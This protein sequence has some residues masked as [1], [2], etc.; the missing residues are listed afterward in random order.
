MQYSTREKLLDYI[1]R[2]LGECETH[3]Y[4]SFTQPMFTEQLLSGRPM[5]GPGDTEGSRVRACPNAGYISRE[6]W[7]N[8]SEIKSPLTRVLF[9]VGAGALP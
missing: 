2:G 8:K 4:S 3:L 7:T 9:G 1:Q 5:L 6:K